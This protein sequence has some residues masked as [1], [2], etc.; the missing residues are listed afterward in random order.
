MGKGVVILLAPSKTMDI[1]S[2][3]PLPVLSQVPLFLPEASKIAAKLHSLTIP[4]IMKLM[5]VSRP[6]AITVQQNYAD[7]HTHEA[8][9]PA[10]WSYSGDVYKGLQAAGLTA[11]DADWAQQH[12]LI[13]SGL[14]GLVRPYDGIQAYRLEMKANLPIERR[15]NLYNFWGDSLSGYVRSQGYDWLCNCSSEEYAKPVLKGL[16][17]P[18]ITPVFFDIKPNGVVG[19]VP[20]YSKLM[21]GVLAR[22]MV[23]NR[24]TSSEQ[25]QTFY[26]HGYSYDAARSRPN[27]PAFSRAKMVPLRFSADFTADF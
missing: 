2:A 5:A 18:V 24:L 7:W 27:A 8:G 12:L 25:L 21:R 6:I 3:P 23:D 13:A 4:K 22:W 20:I 26:A 16:T 17:L 19:S 15:K 9:K 14:Y 11:A 1:R 10:L